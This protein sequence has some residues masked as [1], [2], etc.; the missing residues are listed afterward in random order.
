MHVTE[1]NHKAM[2]QSHAVVHVCLLRSLMD[3]T[4][5]LRISG[6]STLLPEQIACYPLP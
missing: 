6:K 2:F 3:P 4:D 1:R 5:L